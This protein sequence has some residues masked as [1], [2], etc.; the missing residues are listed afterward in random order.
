MRRPHRTSSSTGHPRRDAALGA[1][2]LVVTT[3]VL[4][5]VLALLAPV[6]DVAGVV[7]DLPIALAAVAAAA[8][9][10][11]RAAAPAGGVVVARAGLA[12]AGGAVAVGVAWAVATAADG[13]AGVAAELGQLPAQAGAALLVTAVG[14]ALQ[15]RPRGGTRPGR[16][17]RLVATALTTSVVAT[18]LVVPAQTA[19]A[20]S[21][22]VPG[23]PTPCTSGQEVRRYAVAAATVDVPFNRWGATL[24]SARIFV[25]EQDLAATTHWSRPLAADPATDPANNRRL[26]PRPLVLR[27]NEGEC[28]KV[29]LTNRMSAEAA[30]GLPASPRVGIQAAGVVVD[31]RVD[32]GVR[33]GFDA[34]PT[35]GIG[36]SVSYFWRVPAQEGLF[37]FQD[38]ATPAGGEHDAGSRGVGLYGA[39]AVEPAGSTWTDPRS[40][41]LLSGTVGAPASTYAAVRTQSGDLYVEADIHPPNAPSFRESVQLAQD[42]I[43]GI[44]MGFNYGSEPMA[45]REASAC[46]D[47]L[48][49]ETWL[50]SWPY[51]DPALVKL[52]SGPGPWLPTGGAGAARQEKEDCGLPESCFVSNVVHTYT[53]DPTKIRFGLSGVKETHVFHLHAHQWLADQRNTAL[54]GDGPDAQPQSSTID[55]QS[56]GPGEAYTADLLYGAG[57]KNGTFGDSIFHCHLYPHFAEG[58]WALLRVHDVLLDGGDATPDGVAVRP[59][60]VLKV[61]NGQSRPPAPSADN[62]GYPG[63]IPGT[64]GWRAPQPPGSIT[65]GGVLGTPERP[66]P[67]LVAG[68]TIPA[69]KLAV[70]QAVSQRH[71]GGRAAPRGAPFADPCPT[72]ARVVEYDVTVLQRDL[73]YNEAGHHDPQA[74]FMVLTKDVPDILAGT[75]K[76]EPL[77]LRVNAGDCVDFSLTNMAPNWTGGDAFQQLAQTNMAGGHV[78]LVK[79]DVTASDG[80]S[81]GWNYQ[82]AA[83]TRDQ[84]E[85]TRQQ[86][87][88]LTTCAAGTPFYGGQSTGC[89]LADP[90]GWTPPVD[91][92]GLW[93]QTIHERWYADYE[94]RTVFTHDHHFAA[95]VQNHG[96]FG[97][98]IVEPKGFDV[99]DPATGRYLQPVNSPANGTVCATRCVGDAVGE[100]VDVVGPGA[101]DDYREYGIAIA[102]FVPLVKRG[103]DPRNPHDVVSPPGA[104]EHYPDDDPGTFAINYRNAP[105]VERRVFGGQAVDPAH[106]FSSYVFGDPMTPLLRGYARDNIKLRVIQGSQEEQHLFQ[107]HGLRWREEPDDPGSPLVNAQTIGISEAFNAELPGFDCRSTDTP[108]RGD[109]LYGGTSMDDLWNG[110]WGIMRVHGSLQPD[111]RALPDNPVATNATAV[112]PKPRSR[113]APPA[114]PSPGTACPTTAPVRSYDVVAITRDLVYN[115]HGDHDPQGLMYVLAQDKDAVLAGTKAPEPLVIRANAGDCVRVALTNALPESYAAGTPNGVDGDPALVLEPRG[116]SRMGTR[117]SMHPQLLRHDVRLSDGAAIGFNPDSTVGIGGT[118]RYE[119]YADT[120]LGATNL[121]D[122]GDVRGHRQH[123]L[124]GALVVEPQHATYHDPFTGAPI[125][126]GVT[127]DIRV[128]GQEDF[129]EMTLVYQDGLNLRVAGTNAQV[130]DKKLADVGPDGE[131]VDEVEPDG[132]DVH[133]GGHE[134]A[135]EKGVNYTNAPLHRRLGAAPGQFAAATSDA[136]ADVFSSVVHKDPRTPIARAYE[137]DQLRVRVLG[138]NRPRQMGFALDGAAW[139]SEPYDPGSDLVG[140]QGGIGTGKA[141]NAHVRLPRSGD[142]LWSSPTTFGLPDGVWGLARVYPRPDATAGFSPAARRV[143]DNPFAAG[144]APL[145]PLERASATVRVFTD[146]DGD[147]T[148]DPGED[149]T[150]GVEVRLLTTAGAPVLTAATGPDG[151]VTFSPARASYDVQV[152]PAGGGVVVGAATRRIDLGTD[153]AQAD[154]SVA[155]TATSAVTAAVFEDLD[156]DGVRDDGEPGVAGWTVTLT[157]GSAVAPGLTGGD[158]TAAFAGVPAGSWSAAL[159]PRT[160]WRATTALPLAFT[161]ASDGARVALGVAR[162]PGYPVRVVD[163]ADED[164]VLDDGEPPV[165]GVLV[166]ATPDGGSPVTVRAGPDGVVVDPGGRPAQVGALLPDTLMA[167]VCSTALVTTPTGTTPVPCSPDGT[168]A[169]PADATDVALLGAFTGGVVTTELFAD[170]DRD[171]RRDAGEAALVDWPVELVTPTDHVVVARTTTDADGL[172]GLVAAPGRY[173]VVPQPPTGDVAWTHTA[174]E[175]AVEVARGRGVRS[176]GGWVQPGTVS[177]SVYH[178]LDR[179]GVREDGEGPLGDRTVTLLDAAGTAVLATAYTDGS[180]RA[181]F[182]TQAGTSYRVRVDVPPGWQPTGP[183]QGTT[184]LTTV[185]VTAPADGGPAGVDVGHYNTVDR[186]APLAPVITPG[187]PT[188]VALEVPTLI[189]ITGE[190]SATVRYTLDGTLPTA[191]RGMV[192]AGPVRVSMDRT[193]HAVAVDGAGN[194]SPVAAA[195]FDLPWAGTSAT[196]TPSSWSV[197]S[198]GAPRGGPAQTAADDGTLLAVASVPVA[199][200]PTVDV[201]AT[202]PVPVDLRAARAVSLT[203]SLRSTARSTRVRVQYWDVTAG[204]WR[205]ATTTTQGLDEARVDVDLGA[206]A[207]LVDRAGA[208]RVRLVA[209]N[210]RPFDLQVDHLGLSLVNR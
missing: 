87:A 63:M 21:A 80:G 53:G 210:G 9:A 189:T 188:T 183:Q 12:A 57:S 41:K 62:P 1:L 64:Y 195:Q 155:V 175:Y 150:P 81:N 205:Q 14:T 139:R 209:D 84:A 89:R 173:E 125:S 178:D 200:R 166:R 148:R 5:A 52:A 118:I 23:S 99:R 3:T 136:W 91:S 11:P 50:S 97:A 6:G 17:R 19:T 202:V 102:D 31:V 94:L 77:F 44:G 40:G 46:P 75:K 43:T 206:V 141:V 42:E 68:R 29:T 179:D 147:G 22:A 90:A 28:I 145:Q 123:G 71:N 49:E 110:M 198:G 128:P 101:N 192:Y 34:Q 143:S 33:A 54:T 106:R 121:L 55:S 170:A 156:A 196:V 132:G 92:A 181:A 83:F 7:A 163:D 27:A 165:D 103:G 56:F 149:P 86:A 95:L 96:Q 76:A 174:G 13:G 116:G 172:A 208:V 26:R 4:L 115:E 144:N 61:S 204:L 105:L 159:A 120:E 107:V 138:G 207:N 169:V 78:H 203:A 108:C 15:R 162:T 30:H 32:G 180:G 2:A 60:K 161:V 160:G 51:G 38:M 131:P 193:L 82:Q 109:H 117:V 10:A 111:L 36:E 126:S 66:A 151:T 157:G 69:A 130:P 184:V 201:T 133:A 37:L 72:G 142:H 48:G 185:P 119:W 182:P 171:G 197:T 39:L 140:V 177:V 67:R 137:G 74:R 85:L 114:A 113:L 45:D 168:V 134:D 154:L 124:A 112:T 122:H 70:E 194:V 127:A 153:G 129:R 167:W 146:S 186:I 164:G 158:G 190:T 191:T 93:G 187:G 59:L 152:V 35:V 58:F 79:F 176:V 65:E 104:P 199:S 98:L 24:R 20:T 73:V 135:G 88:G 18:L 100:Q 16:A 25:L 8:A 47:C